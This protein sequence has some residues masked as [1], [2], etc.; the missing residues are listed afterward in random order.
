MLGHIRNS[1]STQDALKE[2]G[3]VSSRY[4]YR[5]A[6]YGGERKAN[7]SISLYVNLSTRLS[8]K[9]RHFLADSQAFGIERC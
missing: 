1:E 4:R 8:L 6:S 7:A 9:M 3:N 5:P 2:C